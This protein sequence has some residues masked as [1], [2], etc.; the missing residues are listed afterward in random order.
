[1]LIG[2]D[3]LDRP[4]WR[5]LHAG[6]ICVPVEPETLADRL[7]RAGFVD[8]EVERDSREPALRFRFAARAPLL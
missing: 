7:A 4:E 1:L 3:S 5:E 6:D 8:I 2:V